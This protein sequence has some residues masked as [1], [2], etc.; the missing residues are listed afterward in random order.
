[1]HIIASR[2]RDHKGGYVRIIK[3]GYRANASDRAPLAIVELVNNPNDVVFH[4]AKQEKQVLDKQL[5]DIEEKRYA[6][7]VVDLI[8]PSTGKPIR[9]LRIKE[10]ADLKVVDKRKLSGQEIAIHKKLIKYNKSLLSYPK[11]REIDQQNTEIL[12]S[13]RRD[14]SKPFFVPPASDI[15]QSLPVQSKVKYIKRFEPAPELPLVDSTVTPTEK[16]VPSPPPKPFLG[17]FFG[18]FFK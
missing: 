11:A 4:L 15:E 6:R 9:L 2:Y 10:R 18:R 3:N 16:K 14:E 13:L 5:D 17:Q 1:M 8:H 12:Q 7:R